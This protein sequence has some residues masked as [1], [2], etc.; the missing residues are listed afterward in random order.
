[1]IVSWSIEIELGVLVFFFWGGVILF[2]VD[3]CSIYFLM[4][5]GWIVYKPFKGHRLVV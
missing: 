1:M 3:F 2:S 5:F 4:V